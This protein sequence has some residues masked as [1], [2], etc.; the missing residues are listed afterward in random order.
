MT[1]D[2]FRLGGMPTPPLDAGFSPEDMARTT[3]SAPVRRADMSGGLSNAAMTDRVGGDDPAGPNVADWLDAPGP[4]QDID[5]GA[6]MVTLHQAAVTLRTAMHEAQQVERDAQ[7]ATMKSEAQD[8]RNSAGFSF[9]AAVVAGAFQI[10]G[11]ALDVGGSFHAYKTAFSEAGSIPAS[12]GPDSTETGQGTGPKELDSDTDIEMKQVGEKSEATQGQ[13]ET[14]L[15]KKIGSDEKRV[16]K[17]EEKTPEQ[18]S[19]KAQSKIKKAQ[20]DINFRKNSKKAEFLLQGYSGLSKAV[21]GIGQI[22]SGGLEYGSHQQDAAEKDHEADATKAAAQV[23][24]Q[25]NLLKN[26]D[27]L[28]SGVRQVFSQMIEAKNESMNKI[29]QA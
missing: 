20:Q 24:D 9:A 16:G 10:A 3:G 19:K 26:I 6:L 14:N 21:G 17:S 11:G 1:M 27:D 18:S 13:E 12:K 7:V 28:I 23:E 2:D 4:G 22:I 15:E 29:T 8:I 5:I 25:A